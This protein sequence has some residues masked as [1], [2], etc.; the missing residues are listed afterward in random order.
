MKFLVLSKDKHMIPPELVVPLIDA[1]T[2]FIDK[3]EATGQLEMAWSNAGTT[4]GG[5]IA[6]VDSLEELD[7]IMAEYPFGPFSDVEVYP[8]ADLKQSLQRTKEVAQMMAQQ[9]GM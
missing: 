4:A 9:M 6:N 1:F 2:A 3:Y 7:A 5:G 8:L